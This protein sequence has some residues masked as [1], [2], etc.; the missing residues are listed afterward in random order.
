MSAADTTP[1]DVSMPSAPDQ[2]MLSSVTGPSAAPPQ[3]PTYDPS[4]EQATE[5]ASGGPPQGSRLGAILTAVAKVVTPAL[6]GIPNQGRPSFATGLG[7]GARAAQAANAV[8]QDI[9]FKTF[10]DQVAAANLHHQDQ[11][12]QLRT[13]EQQDAHQKFEDEQHEFY[14]NQGIDDPWDSVPNSG[15]AVIDRLKAQTAAGGATAP[16]GTHLS[17]DGSSIFMPKDTPE[18]R[19]AQLNEYQQFRQAYA[20]P[21]LPKDAQFVPP[22]LAHMLQYRMEGY[23]QNGT[24]IA[25]DQL[26]TAIANL[27]TQRDQLAKSGANGDQ[28]KRIDLTLGILNANQKA[29]DAHASQYAGQVEA[30]KKAAS[31]ADPDAIANFKNKTL[32]SL[33]HISPALQSSLSSEANGIKNQSDFER[34][35]DRAD[36]FE[37]SGQDFAAKMA[38]TRSTK[39]TARENKVLDAVTDAK[40]GPWAQF[41]DTLTQAKQIQT[42]AAQ[43]K[44]GNGLMTNML[45]T[46]EV[47]G[48]NMEGKV[49]RISPT[50]AQAAGQNPELA[51]RWNAMVDAAAKGAAPNAI[52]K[53]ANDLADMLISG[54]HA[55]AVRATQM[56]STKMD[57]SQVPAMDR[58]GN[59][60]T[61]DKAT[62][63]GYKLGD[64]ITQN[65]K[66]FKVTAVDANGK[67][68]GAQ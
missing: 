31:P 52:V 64:P 59:V 43:A 36:S 63:T 37:K 35:Q 68:T 6:A 12:L 34:L 38:E 41:N 45:P 44:D 58:S 66:T 3:M 30:A 24:P 20:L 55:K 18:M 61:L 17:A 11:E 49:R 33:S 10:Q 9:K 19:A 60:T 39:E 16:P 29:L 23:D 28:L 13:Q 62:T 42:A 67:V 46:M 2:S 40:T 21:A 65:G 1:P 22:Q 5:A 14:R 56:L 47:L 32:P 7:G 26:P 27:Q 50:E 48:I 53:Q 8:Q 15:P 54:A 4:D 51:V 57:P 25:H